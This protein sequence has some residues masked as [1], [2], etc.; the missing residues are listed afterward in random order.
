MTDCVLALDQGTTGTTAV[1]YK[2][3]TWEKVT[4]ANVTFQ[5]HYPQPGWVEHDAEEIWQSTLKAVNLALGQAPQKIRIVCIGITN[6]REST[7]CIDRKTGTP[8]GRAIVWQDR[9]TALR[10]NEIRANSQIHSQLKS[11]T[12]LVA[13]PYF[14]AT[15]M[16]WMMQEHPGVRTAV[17][18]GSA[19]L[20]TIDAFLIARLTGMSQVCTDPT[21]ACRTMLY[22]LKT[23]DYDQELLDLFGIPRNAL[24]PIRPSIGLFGTAQQVPGVA[25]GT[26]I[27]AV[28]GDQQAALFGQRALLPGEAKVTFGTGAFL[29]MNTGINPVFAQDAGLL[30]SV[31]LCSGPSGKGQ[32]TYCLEG[33]C[34]IAG[35][36]IQFL[37]DQFSFFN[38]AKESEALALSEPRDPNVTFVPSLAG[39]GAPFWNPNAKGVLFGLTRGNSRAQVTRAVLES[40]AL[41]NVPLLEA[42]QQHSGLTLKWLAVDGGAAANDYLVQFQ[43]DVLQTTLRRPS[44]LEATSL[45]AARA[46][47]YGFTGTRPDKDT[48]APSP[49]SVEEIKPKITGSEANALRSNWLRAANAVHNY[50]SPE[51]GG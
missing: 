17:Q 9:R 38:H 15:K 49:A 39:L 14:S 43:S 36:A 45:G 11:R 28:L 46:A 32:L 33:A 13:D 27:S 5:Q 47:W 29:L 31:A 21:N 12:G 3:E 26:P 19:L 4:Q 22:N 20:T 50:Y 10:C 16:E 44:D 24:P 42:M 34:F 1:L 40:I 48:E 7:V 37:R 25:Q 30:T 2:P 35:A 23:N 8:L 6:Q 18:T 41:Q 51:S